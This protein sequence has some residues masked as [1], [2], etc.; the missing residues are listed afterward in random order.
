MKKY[1]DVKFEKSGSGRETLPAG[2]Y[3]CQIL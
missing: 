2:G 3:V 1:S